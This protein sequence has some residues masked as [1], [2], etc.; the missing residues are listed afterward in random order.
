MQTTAATHPVLAALLIA[1]E[2]GRVEGASEDLRLALGATYGHD[3]ALYGPRWGTEETRAAARE[4]IRWAEA[5]LVQP[6]QAL[7]DGAFEA[8][9]DLNDNS[10]SWEVGWLLAELGMAELDGGG[11]DPV[12]WAVRDEAELRWRRWLE[13]YDEAQQ[14][15][16]ETAELDQVLDQVDAAAA[17]VPKADQDPAKLA[18]LLAELK[19]LGLKARLFIG[20]ESAEGATYFEP[21]E[22]VERLL[23]E[24]GRDAERLIAAL[25]A[26]LDA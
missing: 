4:L 17:A 16:A 3:G 23:D 7:S 6:G 18:A 10:F 12:V 2:G 15:A 19:R 14:I 13:V 5:A 25:D 24:A 11:E 21:V 8:L 20:F 9:E 22:T 26:N 1:A